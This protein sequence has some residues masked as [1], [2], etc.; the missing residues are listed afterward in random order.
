[1][2][3]LTRACL[4]MTMLCAIAPG[5]EA[6]PRTSMKGWELYTWFDMRCSASPQLHSG[7]NPDS[8]CVALVVGTNRAKT[9]RE[10]KRA[11]HLWADLPGLLGGLARGETVTWETEVG[12]F[13]PPGEA[14]RAQV[15]AHAKRAGLVLQTAARP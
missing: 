10:I 7:P 14:L 11:V 2:K 1:M 15:A 3:L 13:D 9:A 4:T 12:V 5:A 8:W 6:R